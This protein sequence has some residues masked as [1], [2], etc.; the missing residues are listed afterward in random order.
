VAGRDGVGDRVELDADAVAAAGL[1]R[2][3]VLVRVA[4]AQVEEAARDER[5][6]AVGED[7]AEPHAH[8]RLRPVGLELE[9]DGGDAEHDRLLA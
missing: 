8:E 9:L 3:R 1:E 6:G 7:V 4:V 2:L 5:G